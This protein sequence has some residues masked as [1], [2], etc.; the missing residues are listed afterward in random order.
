MNKNVWSIKACSCLSVL[1]LLVINI[2]FV[3]TDN[4]PAFLSSKA[5]RD[6]GPKKPLFKV[7]STSNE[8]EERVTTKKS[9][10]PAKNYNNGLYYDTQV[11]NDDETEDMVIDAAES[12]SDSGKKSSQLLPPYADVPLDYRRVCIYP[13][14]SILRESNMAKIYPEDIDPFLCTHIQ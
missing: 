12:I 9:Y 2:S 1:L 6:L 11:L 7:L 4:E 8:K 14:W 10:D 13:N 3:Q 5:T